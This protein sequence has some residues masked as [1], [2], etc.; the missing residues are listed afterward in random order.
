MI[1]KFEDYINEATIPNLNG[2]G[3]SGD[4]IATMTEKRIEALATKYELKFLRQFFVDEDDPKATAEALIAYSNLDESE[5]TDATMNAL[6]VALRPSLAYY[7]AY[8]YFSDE[9]VKNATIGGTITNSPNGVRHNNLQRCAKIW[10]DMVDMI[11]E[12]YEDEYDDEYPPDQDIFYYTNSF[13]I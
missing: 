3:T 11:T 10:N 8:N 1:T 7:I 13:N 9:T 12:V 6:I 4:P 5:K 2:A